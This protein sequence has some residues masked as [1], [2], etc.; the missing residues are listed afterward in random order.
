MVASLDKKKYR[1][2]NGVFAVE[3]T[4]AVRDTWDYFSCRMIIATKQ[5][6]DSFGHSGHLG[7]IMFASKAQLERMSHFST[8][9][10][11]IAIYDLPQYEINSQEI[12]SG[13]TIALDNIQD[14]GNLGTIIRIADWFGIKNIVCSDTTVDVFNHKVVQAT[15]GAISRVKVHYVDLEDFL[16][17]DW[18]VPVYGT[19]LDGENI[20][21]STLSPSGIVVMG[22]EGKGISPV[23]TDCISHR[24][25]IPSYPPGVP[26]SESLNVGVAT[27][28]TIGEF[29]RRS[30]IK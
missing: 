16:S 29:R 6:Y 30:F 7:K 9:S 10:D 1:V 21:Q 3:G 26:T 22:N 15:M 20:Y 12:S 8:A 4:K 28:I 24:L 14:P 18:G 17:Q 27:A 23:L 25:L 5:W 13:L 19:Y 11:V 2:E